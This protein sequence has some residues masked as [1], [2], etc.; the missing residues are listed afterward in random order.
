M[1]ELEILAGI[2]GSDGHIKKNKYRLLVINKNI[3]FLNSVVIPLINKVTQKNPK[4]LFNHWGRGS[5]KFFVFFNS[6]FLWKILQDKFNI[7]KGKK[8]S[9]IK[10]PDLK[11][12][13]AKIDFLRGWFAGDGSVT[14]DKSRPRLEIWSNSKEIIFWIKEVLEENQIYPRIHFAKKTKQFLL[15]IKKRESVKTFHKI[16]EIPHPNK[17]NKLNAL[18]SDIE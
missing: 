15:D 5:G 12:N 18:L 10:P 1:S 13:K 7:P 11:T 6:E 8:S 16:I 9:K 3:K 2:I 14:T 17:E 4:P